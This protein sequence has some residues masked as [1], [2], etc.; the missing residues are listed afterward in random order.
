MRHRK[1][2]LAVSVVLIVLALAGI[3]IRGLSLGVEFT[4]GRLMEYTATQPV[5]IG[6]ARQAV[7]DAGFPR[8]VVVE[9]GDSDV[10]VRTERISDAEEQQIRAALTEASG[11][12]VERIRDE[13]IGPSLGSELRTKALIGLAVALFAQ[14]AYLALR[15][16]WTFALSSVVAMLHDVLIVVGLFAWLGKSLDGVFLAALLTVIGYSVNDSVVIFDRVRER[17]RGANR[18]APFADVANEAVLQTVPRTVNTG[19]GALFIL[20]ALAVLGGDSL[21][22]FAIALLAGV[23]VGTASSAL[24]ATPLAVV[25]E[26]KWPGRVRGTAHPAAKKP[27]RAG[28]GAVV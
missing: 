9:S 23:V 17:R 27:A 6:D 5:S 22:D 7:A 14:A 26:N 18:R 21:T 12:S 3:G 10:S 11:G 25:L 4:G 24:T 15:F 19:L 20:T 13:Q 8:A 1:V 16:R 28:S 2:Y